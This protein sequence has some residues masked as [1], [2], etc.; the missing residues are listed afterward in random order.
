VLELGRRHFFGLLAGTAAGIS[1]AFPAEQKET[2][3]IGFLRARAR[4]ESRDLTAAF[5]RRLEVD[6]IVLGRD[7][8]IEIL[9]GGLPI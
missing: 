6:G 3:R 9:L 5:I 7:V 4:E 8:G 2:P 1:S